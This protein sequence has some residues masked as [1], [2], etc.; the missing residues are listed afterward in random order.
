MAHGAGL[1]L[2]QGACDQS[3]QGKVTAFTDSGDEEVIVVADQAEFIE[4]GDAA[5]DLHGHDQEV[6]GDSAG[7]HLDLRCLLPAESILIV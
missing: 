5:A 1:C 6:A 4:A 2:A 3:L 7:I